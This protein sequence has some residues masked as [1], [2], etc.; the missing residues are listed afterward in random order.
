MERQRFQ[1]AVGKCDYAV[2]NLGTEPGN[3]TWE[4]EEGTTWYGWDGRVWVPLRYKLFL[5]YS[6]GGTPSH[7]LAK[8][9]SKVTMNRQ[10]SF[11]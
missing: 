1:Q 2:Y 9:I 5:V 6:V 7:L 11:G 10:F 3:R 8:G 4:L